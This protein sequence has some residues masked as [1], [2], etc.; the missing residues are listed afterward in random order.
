MA[1]TLTAAN[2]V[3][4]LGITG[5]FTVP[6]Q[7]QGFE[8]DDIFSM[9][10][11]KSVET[12]MGVDGKL[13]GGWVPT[14]KPMGYTLQADSDS[15]DLFE[16]WWQTQE[17]TKETLIG[18]GVIS[19]PSLGKS[20]ALTQGFLGDYTPIPDAKK[21]MQSRKYSIIWGSVLGSPI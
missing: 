8:V 14:E 18:F 15:N 6:Q 10:S 20:F 11:V 21:I 1:K 13:S 9:G 19:I 7:L 3:I 16:A 12:K 17:A 4:T 2:C 5:I